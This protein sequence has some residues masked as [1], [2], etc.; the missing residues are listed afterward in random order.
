LL[1]VRRP[2]ERQEL[3]AALVVATF[4]VVIMW[5]VVAPGTRCN[6][7]RRYDEDRHKQGGSEDCPPTNDKWRVRVR[8]NRLCYLGILF[9]DVVAVN[10]ALTDSPKNIIRLTP[11]LSSVKV[12]SVSMLG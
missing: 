12:E 6:K 4:A 8:T 2:V 5:V 9:F 7:K 11:F 3:V 10:M 1:K